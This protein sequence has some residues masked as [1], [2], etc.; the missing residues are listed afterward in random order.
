MPDIILDFDRAIR[1]GVEEAIF[2]E[3]KSPRQIEHII[4][5]ALNE[6]KNLLF[7]RLYPEKFLNI[8]STFRSKID[9]CEVSNTAI[10]GLDK[11]ESI[12]LKCPSQI[13]IISGG[14]SD[15]SV[16]HEI[17]RTLTYHGIGAVLYED[18][19]VSAMWRLNDI[20]EELSSM[21]IIVAVAGMEAALPTVL[22]GLV[23][24]PIIAV[25]TSVGYGVSAGGQLA[26]NS[27]LGSC[28]AGV[29]T[30]NI[31]NGFGAACAA[32]KICKSFSI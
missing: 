21:K 23:P 19:G 25:P 15:T 9:Y 7:T 12:P 17:R 27:C 8:E 16:C 29:L 32:I 3:S 22:A 30:V 4:S 14:A 18:V 2:C 11:M 28:A 6:D 13:A 24:T 20:L 1:C 5:L 10:L 26:L 31:D